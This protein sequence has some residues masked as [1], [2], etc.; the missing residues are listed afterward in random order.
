MRTH[1][2]ALGTDAKE[3]RFDRIKIQLRR[4]RPLKD[5]IQRLGQSFAR[6]FSIGRSIFVTIRNPDVGDAGGA[7]RAADFR[8]DLPAGDAMLDPELTNRSVTM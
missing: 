2:I 3:F 5:P 4:E 1:D 6:S 8:A 7:Q